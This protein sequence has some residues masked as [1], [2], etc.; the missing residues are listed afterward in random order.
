MQDLFSAL[1][2]ADIHRPLIR[3][4]VSLRVSQDLF[5]DLSDDPDAWRSAQALEMHTK[6]GLYQSTQPVIDR[7][8]EQAEWEDAIAYPFKHTSV[9]RY[10]DGGFGVWYGADTIETSVYETVHHWKNRLLDDAGYTQAGIVMERKVYQVQCDA[11]LIDLRPM[12]A[13]HPAITH[14]SDYTLTHQIGSKFYREGHPGLV[15]ASARVANGE[16]YA[17]FNAKVLSHPAMICNLT[18]TTTSSGVNVE[19]EIGCDF[20][21]IN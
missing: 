2:L 11:L 10:S 19:R 7:P 6:P 17:L 20:M 15:T 9:S 4:I 3:N 5:D 12:I 16:V 8:F 1:T 18:Y 21:C 14:A 13:N